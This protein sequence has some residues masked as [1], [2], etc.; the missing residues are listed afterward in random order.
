M[1]D[2]CLSLERIDIILCVFNF[3]V[4]TKSNKISKMSNSC[5]RTREDLIRSA[6]VRHHDVI[7]FDSYDDPEPTYCA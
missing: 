2:L 6:W 7:C 1:K 4:Q 5:L 3:P